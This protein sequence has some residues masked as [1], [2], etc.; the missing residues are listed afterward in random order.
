MLGILVTPESLEP[1]SAAHC[2]QRKMSEPQTVT[3]ATTM[4]S[5]LSLSRPN[6][7]GLPHISSLYYR[8]QKNLIL[9]FL[10]KH[11]LQLGCPSSGQWDNGR[12]FPESK[13]K[14]FMENSLHLIPFIFK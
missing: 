13:G 9:M 2:E 8:T 3:K 7:G 10:V 14:I 4:K 1:H 12:I 11:P 5:L 6:Q